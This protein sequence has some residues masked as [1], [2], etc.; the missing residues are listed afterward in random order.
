MKIILFGRNEIV[1]FVIFGIPYFVCLEEMWIY[2]TGVKINRVYRPDEK[3]GKTL[4]NLEIRNWQ[5]KSCKALK[6]SKFRVKPWKRNCEFE[7]KLEDPTW[8]IYIIYVYL[9]YPF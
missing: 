9:T 4:K 2:F 8:G 5:K 1:E 7:E 6:F 3:F